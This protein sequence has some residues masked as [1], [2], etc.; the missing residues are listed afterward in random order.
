[1]RSAESD[2]GADTILSDIRKNLFGTCITGGNEGKSSFSLMTVSADTVLTTSSFF[3]Y[4]GNKTVDQV[5]LS[6]H[7]H[8]SSHR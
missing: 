7:L 5:E 6:C 2:N 3:F 1:M 4:E 8:T